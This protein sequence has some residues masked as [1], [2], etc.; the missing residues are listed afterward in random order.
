MS[1]FVC[2]F[3]ANKKEANAQLILGV[4]FFFFA[5]GTKHIDVFWKGEQY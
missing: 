3:Y 5:F 1:Y 4:R 2:S